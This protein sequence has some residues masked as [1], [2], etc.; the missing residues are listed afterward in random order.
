MTSLE[1]KEF[2]VNVWRIKSGIRCEQF[3]G[4]EE[5]ADFLLP[6]YPCTGV[7]DCLFSH[8]LKT[9]S[10]SFTQTIIQNKY[11]ADKCCYFL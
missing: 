8:T 4:R 7:W 5:L 11:V 3:K 10:K 6:T 2:Y 9:S 1:I